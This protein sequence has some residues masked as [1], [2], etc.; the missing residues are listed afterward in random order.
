MSVGGARRVEGSVCE[1]CVRIE[2]SER[3]QDGGC[4]WSIFWRSVKKE[5]SEKR[6]KECRVEKRVRASEEGE[7]V[8]RE[9]S[10]R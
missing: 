9:V 10:V 2:K 1:V 3:M 6:K 7:C 4:Q 8:R 5:K